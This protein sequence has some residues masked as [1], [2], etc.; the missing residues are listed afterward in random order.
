MESELTTAER[1]LDRANFSGA[2]QSIRPRSEI[3]H[4]TL[5]RARIQ[6]NSPFNPQ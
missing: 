2:P 4:K 5:L 6:T 1:G 3:E